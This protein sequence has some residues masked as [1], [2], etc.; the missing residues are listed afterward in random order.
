MELAPQLSGRA[1]QV[2]A[3][4]EQIKTGDYD[5]VKA[6]ILRYNN[7]ETNPQRFWAV[8]KEGESH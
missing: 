3:A 6:A 7:D 2:F 4:M 8:V 5:E 1:Q